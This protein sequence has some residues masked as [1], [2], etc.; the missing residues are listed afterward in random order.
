LDSNLPPFKSATLSKV[1]DQSKNPLESADILRCNKDLANLIK[2]IQI[3][4]VSP[5]VVDLSNNSL[6][7]GQQLHTHKIELE[8]LQKRTQNLKS[9]TRS[10]VVNLKH[11]AKVASSFSTFPTTSA[12][13]SFQQSSPLFGKVSISTGN[14]QPQK[15]TQVVMDAFQ[16]QKVHSI[17]VQ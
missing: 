4:R 11:G 13:Q 6:P 17:F 15:V 2:E 12:V 14:T 5:K 3:T 10:L 1:I 9:K 7:V 8:M 16:F